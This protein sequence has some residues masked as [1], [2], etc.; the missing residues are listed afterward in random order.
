MGFEGIRFDYSKGYGGSFAGDYARAALG[1][2]DGFVVG[3]YWVP[4]QYDDEGDMVYDQEPN[5]K[6]RSRHAQRSCGAGPCTDRRMCVVSRAVCDRR[7]VQEVTKWIDDTGGRCL[8]FDFATKG[9]L[10]VRVL[11]SLCRRWLDRGLHAH[12]SPCAAL[13]RKAAAPGEFRCCRQRV[14]FREGLC[15]MRSASTSTTG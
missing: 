9:I 5:R 7:S 11:G 4:L 15:R 13:E 14:Y 8:A 6:A 10:Q 3:E 1:E 2:C 12:H